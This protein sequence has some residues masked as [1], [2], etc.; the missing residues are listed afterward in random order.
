MLCFRLHFAKDATIG[1]TAGATV[2]QLVSLVFERVVIEDASSNEEALPAGDSS[3]SE[4]NK[5]FNKLP[6]SPLK[7]LKP[8]AQD[9]F[10][11]FQ[12]CILLFVRQLHFF[13]NLYLFPKDL[14][15]LVNG[16]QPSWLIGMT[17]MTRTFGIELLENILST[18]YSV[19][20]K[21]LLKLSSCR[22]KK[23]LT[24]DNWIAPGI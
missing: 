10:S 24:L 8:S 3:I 11:L 15:M 18:F 14:V 13:I 5:D 1:N 20:F 4:G 17:E 16:D 19:F 12:V 9:A 22:K 2:R 7:T 6:D 23:C 21:V